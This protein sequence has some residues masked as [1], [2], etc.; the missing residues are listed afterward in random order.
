MTHGD[1][2]S[3]RSISSAPHDQNILV[4]SLRW[5]TIVASF[6]SE[7]GVW[8]PRMQWPA[9]LNHEDAGLITHWMP[10]PGVPHELTRA[11]SPWHSLAA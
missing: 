10:M 11:R 9:A 6:S 4:Y 8:L 3:W 7:L 1:R 2:V 5:G